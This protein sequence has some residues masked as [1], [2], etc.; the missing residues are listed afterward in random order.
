MLLIPSQSSI[1]HKIKLLVDYS[2]SNDQQNR[3]RKLNNN[4][5]LSEPGTP[6]TGF[7]TPSK[8]LYRLK[9]G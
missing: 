6:G 1:L 4:Q 9:S 8:D 2:R 7:K 5:N 3:E